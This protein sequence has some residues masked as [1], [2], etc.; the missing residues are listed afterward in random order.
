MRCLRLKDRPVWL[1][2]HTEL[3]KGALVERSSLG[4]ALKNR[5][6]RFNNYSKSKRDQ[7]K[8]FKARK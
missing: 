3:G 6:T 2:G 4:G 5:E 8:N 7:L 1:Y